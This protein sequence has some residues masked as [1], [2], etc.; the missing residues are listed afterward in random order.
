MALKRVANAQP[1]LQCCNID[2]GAWGGGA[3]SFDRKA[4]CNAVA[5]TSKRALRLASNLRPRGW[6]KQPLEQSLVV[7]TNIQRGAM[8]KKEAHSGPAQAAISMSGAQTQLSD[9][10]RQRSACLLPVDEL[11]RCVLMLKSSSAKLGRK[12]LTSTDS[13]PS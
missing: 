10:R 2:E 1:Q 6:P 13:G 3:R 11:Y 12:L 5:T 8:N 7:A 4:G 9:G